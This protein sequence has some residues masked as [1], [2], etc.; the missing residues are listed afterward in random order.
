MPED[1]DPRTPD[2]AVAVANNV[3]GDAAVAPTAAHDGAD[4]DDEAVARC[5]VAVR[6]IRSPS[7]TKVDESM[8]AVVDALWQGDAQVALASYAKSEQFRRLKTQSATEMLVDAKTLANHLRGHLL[9]VPLGADLASQLNLAQRVALL[10]LASAVGFRNELVQLASEAVSTQATDRELKQRVAALLKPAR[11]PPAATK[12]V[13][14][15]LNKLANTVQALTAEQMDSVYALVR[16]VDPDSGHPLQVLRMLL[17]STAPVIE[18]EVAAP[19]R[20]RTPEEIAARDEEKLRKKEA[21]RAA[22]DGGTGSPVDAT[23]VAARAVDHVADADGQHEEPLVSPKASVDSLELQADPAEVTGRSP[24][25]VDAM[26]EPLA[27]ESGAEL[28]EGGGGVTWQPPAA[29]VDATLVEADGQAATSE[30]P[31]SPGAES[32]VT[33]REAEGVVQAVAKARRTLPPARQPPL[34]SPSADPHATDR[35]AEGVVQAVAKAPRL[36]PPARSPPL[37]PSDGVKRPIQS[38]RAGNTAS[39]RRSSE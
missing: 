31:A 34:A 9:C 4:T 37:A 16:A 30:P 22:R 2:Q 13:M 35:E 21:K 39:L 14:N 17:E 1:D 32:P 7:P 33:D 11:Q 5:L 23:D 20:E 15:L 38:G 25:E 24:A 27:A 36:L 10:P 8:S 26:P 18:E 28:Q 12:V 3:E 29:C 19:R 6:E